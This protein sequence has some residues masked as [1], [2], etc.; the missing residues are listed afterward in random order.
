[1]GKQWTKFQ[2]KTEKVSYE[3]SF[4]DAYYMMVA[5]KKL[6]NMHKFDV[7]ND[8]FHWPHILSTTT[9]IGEIYHLDYS[10]NIAQQYKYEP[11]SAH[12]S[13]RQFSLHCTVKHTP[14]L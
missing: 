2:K 7:Y 4:K 6:D 9:D 11:Q 1:M 14:T 3:M 10:E 5:T 12:C 13:K 8:T